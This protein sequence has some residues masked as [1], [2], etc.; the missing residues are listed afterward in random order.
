MS[1]IYHIDVTIRSLL[2][3]VSISVITAAE[4]RL[5]YPET[6]RVDQVD[7]VLLFLGH[8]RRDRQIIGCVIG[9]EDAAVHVCMEDHL[10][11]LEEHPSLIRELQGAGCQL[12]VEGCAGDG[13]HGKGRD[14]VGVDRAQDLSGRTGMGKGSLPARDSKKH[15]DRQAESRLL[16][17]IGHFETVLWA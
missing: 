3:L 16:D 4:D 17:P 12:I 6:R 8:P 5:V 14:M 7:G 10:S 11:H 2:V 13:D 1:L 9:C 15:H